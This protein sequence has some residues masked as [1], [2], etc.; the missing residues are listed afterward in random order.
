MI[1]V[2]RQY[3]EHVNGWVLWSD[4][5]F[6]LWHDGKIRSLTES[7][8]ERTPAV[9]AFFVGAMKFASAPRMRRFLRGAFAGAEEVSL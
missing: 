8:G 7:F 5:V 4:R 9:I 6:Y 3:E 1:D 2:L